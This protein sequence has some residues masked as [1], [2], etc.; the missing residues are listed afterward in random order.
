MPTFGTG[1]FIFANCNLQRA[2]EVFVFW[3]HTGHTL[4]LY[5]TGAVPILNMSICLACGN[6][7]ELTSELFLIIS[8]RSLNSSTIYCS[9]L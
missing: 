9:I 1:G 6:A 7:L 4:T 5:V 3:L 2:T 8:E